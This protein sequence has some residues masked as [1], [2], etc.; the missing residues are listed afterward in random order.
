MHKVFLSSTSEDLAGYRDAVH[1]AIDGLP[2]FQLVRME[3]FGGRDA[4][5]KDLCRRLVRECELFVGL[6]GHYYGSCPPNDN[7]SF[8]EFEY[9]TA[10]E[11]NLPRLMFVAPEDF[12]IPARLRETDGSFERQKALRREVLDERVVASFDTPEQLAS[13]ITQAL[14]IWYREQHEAEKP[15]AQRLTDAAAGSTVRPEG[16]FG[17][18]PYRGLEAFRKQDADRFFGR[19][20]LVDRAWSSFLSL[21]GVRA[22]GKPSSRLITILGASGSG[23]S[24]LAQ[25][26]LLAELEKRPLPGSPAPVELVFTPEARP[27]ESLAVALARAATNDPSPV[28]KAA[29]FEEAL[30]TRGRYDG[31]RFLAHRMLGGTGLILLVDQFEEV[32][33]LCDDEQERAAFIGNL[34]NAVRERDGRVSV[35]STLRSDFLGAVNQ[36]PELSG[37]VARQNVV[38]PVMEEAE[39]RCAIEEPARQAGHEIDPRTV[40]LLVG[41]SLGRAGALPLL[42]FVLTRIWDGIASGIPASVTVSELGG[43]GG[44]LARGAQ[45]VYDNLNKPDREIARRAFRAMVRLS[46]GAT[47]TRRRARVSEMV[48]AGQSSDAVVRVLRYFAE[49]DCRLITLAGEEDATTAEVAHEALFDHW[50]LLK[51]WLDEARNELW[52]DHRRRWP[53]LLTLLESSTFRL[54]LILSALFGVSALALFGFLYVRTAVVMEQQIRDTINTE[55]IALKEQSQT[56]GLVGLKQTIDRRS[57]D[58]PDRASVYLL[59]DRLNKRIAGNLEDW[60]TDERPPEGWLDFGIQVPEGDRTTYRG[61]LGKILPLPDGLHLLV[62]RDTE[63]LQRTQ[64]LLQNAIG[65]GLCLTLLLG[66]VGGFLMSYGM[67]S[68]IAAI[69]RT[70]RRIMAGDLSQRVALKGSRDE[71]DQLAATLN[72]MLD[73]I[74]RTRGRS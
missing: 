12:A 4:T 6:I 38:V 65:W 17:R 37:L 33:S 49:P 43:V 13:A 8:T 28:K 16:K 7:I 15:P 1:R 51:D 36:H 27:L 23:K 11:A 35:I 53:G 22:D 21:H 50:Q 46:E 62:G 61:A 67:L 25:A 60:P 74:E 18:N 66:L 5:P 56:F 48:V 40:A 44:A 58:N 47:A 68:R 2:G 26:G 29:E 57:E 9:R 69:N 30:R 63:N 20:P 19:Q 72:A 52:L 14:F 42:E 70:T 64:S 10:I 54:A 32:Y 55:I 24:S 3:D 73:R 34:L 59:T 41:Q 71:F 45:H 31:L 39:L